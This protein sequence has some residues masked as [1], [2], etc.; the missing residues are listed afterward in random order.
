MAN[1]F[2]TYGTNSTNIMY[3]D[4]ID[5]VTNIDPVDTYILNN[6]GKARAKQRYHEWTTD[7]LLAVQTSGQLEGADFSATAL[8]GASRLGNYCQISREQW[9]ITDTM[10]ATDTVGGNQ[11]SYQMQRHLKSLS[12]DI[13]YAL[14]VNGASASGASGVARTSQGIN[15]WIT[16]NV[17]SAGSASGSAGWSAL[18][19]D[20][21]NNCLQSIWA[22][23]GKPSTALVGG[24]QKRKI[25]NFHTKTR[26]VG[27][28][29]S[30]TSTV[31]SVDIYKSDFGDLTIK[32]HQQMQSSLP[33]SVIILGDMS[34]WKTAW[35]R[36]IKSEE[37]AR[38]GSAKKYMVEAEYTL[39]S[40]QEKG[41]GKIQWLTTS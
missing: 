40:R 25:S 26:D 24:F 4:L 34:L 11:E 13:E 30:Q 27:Q 38:T 35:L 15:T 37:I 39:E 1:E 18:T 20:H 9:A 10:L 36:P 28:S 23:G 22:D 17:V 19:V 12:R 32:L 2:S 5:V 31:E 29:T 21:V 33:G 14:L 41:S 6:A 16:D 7:T 8:T 3:D